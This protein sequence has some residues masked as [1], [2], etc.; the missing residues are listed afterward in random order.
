MTVNEVVGMVGLGVLV[1]NAGIQ[2]GLV[3]A[4]KS[5]HENEIRRLEENIK[6]CRVGWEGESNTINQRFDRLES[7]LANVDKTTTRLEERIQKIRS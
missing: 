5:Q 7:M 3:W 2:W 1:M 6:A 4:A